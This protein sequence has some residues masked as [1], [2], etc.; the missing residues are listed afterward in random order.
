MNNSGIV[1]LC[2]QLGAVFLYALVTV[3]CFRTK[4]SNHFSVVYGFYILT[5]SA[6]VIPYVALG[7]DS[8]WIFLLVTGAI[9]FAQLFYDTRLIDKLTPNNEGA[10]VF[11]IPFMVWVLSW[12]VG[13]LARWLVPRFAGHS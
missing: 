11:I 7:Q 12:P 5:L 4:K 6:F 3:R 2:L 10:I 13:L 9:W 1:W 8:F